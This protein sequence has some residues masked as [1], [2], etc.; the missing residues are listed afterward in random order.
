MLN[1][2]VTNVANNGREVFIWHRAGKTLSLFKDNSYFPYFYQESKTGLFKT[3]DNKKVNKIFCSRPS[4]VSKRRDENSYEADVL[5]YRRYVIDKI[6]S[7]LP[8]ELKYSFVDIEVQCPELPSILNPIYPIVCISCSN[9]YTQEIKTFSITAF[10]S[11]IPDISDEDAEKGVLSDF[12]AWIR[13]EKFD[14]LAGWNFI[15]FDY[16]YLRAR[17][18]KL[19]GKELADE[20]SPINSNRIVGK[21]DEEDPLKIP[22][23]LG[24]VDYLAWFKKIY[25]GRHS[26][27]LDYIAQEE[28]KETAY[29]KVDFNV[30]SD[31]VK[32]KN[33]NDVRRMVDIEKKLKIINYF[34]ELRRMSKSDWQDLD[35]NC[36]DTKTEILTNRGWKKYNQITLEDKVYSM[37]L[38]NQKLELKKIDNIFIYNDY[39]GKMISYEH[40][41]VNFC[42]TL[43]HRFLMH[44]YRP[45]RNIDKLEF[46]VADEITEN[47]RFFIVGTEGFEGQEFLLDNQVRLIGW[48]LSEGHFDSTCKGIHIYQNIGKKANIIRQLLKDLKLEFSEYHYPQSQVTNKVINFRILAHND[49]FY[50]DLLK[51]KKEIPNICYNLSVRQ[52]R[53]LIE[54]MMQGDGHWYTKNSGCYYSSSFALIEQ[55]QL[56]ATL[57]GY[58]VRIESDIRKRDDKIYTNYVARILKKKNVMYRNYLKNYIDYKGKIWCISTQFENF[59]IRRNNKVMISG[60]SKM[61]DMMLLTE[62]HQKGIV[63]PSKKYGV[64]TD[65]TF[66]GAYRRCDTGLYKNLWKLDL[67]SAY[68]MA[69]IN[70][71][72]DVQ[73]IKE[74]EGID[75]NGTKFYQNSSA[76]LPSLARKLIIKKDDL[77]KQLKALDPESNEAKDLQVKYDAVKGVVNSLFGVCGLKVFRLFDMRVAGA[78]TFIVRDLL[79]YI[80]AELEKRSVKIIY[81]DTDSVF[82]DSKENPKDMLNQ[83]VAQW[84]KEK[85]NKDNVGIEFDLEGKIN[86]ILIVA[87]CHYIAEVD[88][89]KG[90]KKEIKGVEVKRSDSSKYMKYFQE[91]LIDKVMNDESREAIEEFIASEKEAIKQKSLIEIGFPCKVSGKTDYK[92]LPIFMRGLT[93]TQEI[94]PSFKKVAGD[95]FYYISV[96]PFGTSVR[97]S[98]RVKRSKDNSVSTLQ[99]S[100]T[101]IDK[102]VLCFDDD[103]QVHIQNIDW[104]QVIKKS[105]DSKVDKIFEAM[106]WTIEKEIKVKKDKKIK[107][108]KIVTVEETRVSKKDV[109]TKNFTPPTEEIKCLLE[110]NVLPKVDIMKEETFNISH[111][112][113]TKA[114]ITER[115]I[116]VA[117]AFGLGIDE[118]KS[119]TLYDN[120]ELKFK[121]GDIVYITG[122][123]GSGK[124]WMLNNIFAKLDNSIAISDLKVDDNE[125]IVEGVGKDLND[126]LM[127]L[128]IAGLGDAFLYL[129]KYSQLSDGQKYRY[130]IAKFIDQD[131]DIWIL[132]EFCATLDRVTAKVVAYNLQKIARKLNKTIVVA[133]THTDLLEE[134]RPTVHIVKG[135]ESD[136]VITYYNHSNWQDKKLEF[137]QDIKVEVGTKD[138]YSALKRFHYRQAS[139]GAVKHIYKCTYKN[140]LIGVMVITYPHLAL[141]ARN[142]YTNNL[143]SKMTKENC[144]QINKNFSCIARVVLHPKWRGIGLAHYFVKEYLEKFSDTKYVETLA[145]M[146]RYSAFFAR[147]GMIQVEVDDDTLRVNLVKQLEEFGYNTSLLSSI[148][149]NEQIFNTLTSEQKDKIKEIV[150]IILTKYKGQISKLYSSEKSID[151]LVEEHLFA[152]MKELQRP[153]TLYWIWE[154]K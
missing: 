119:F 110:V 130:R 146:S 55:F 83:L 150:K 100:E 122:D 144:E 59:I 107:E 26:Y 138:D 16:Q 54:T 43:N 101:E 18:Y 128:N 115:T 25:K 35:W 111:S 133:T 86:K 56:L 1:L 23:G 136:I 34:D 126:A 63:L 78:I 104:K 42:C 152:L 45:I 103:N 131:K 58:N 11:N 19:F 95:S 22:T 125:V 118:E 85:Y 123:S 20:L 89:K 15:D 24:I 120:V 91:T 69:I 81:I 41:R 97:K 10:F 134:I 153:D 75:I 127:K 90:I 151:A 30:L 61:L 2:A 77:K 32:E 57:A 49:G 50:R 44:N 48:I 106:K 21:K 154:K 7:F 135:Y 64:E 53:L 141:K 60:N 68:P 47:G 5:Y 9:S 149:Y 116:M 13:T 108:T 70:F 96:L 129:R 33:I 52:K 39:K 66:E 147:A 117:E 148:R 145:V 92:S 102:N 88:T 132:D 28:L 137:Y 31:K 142:I 65:E 87:L 112:F 109:W 79:H 94:L 140:D 17:Y 74:N 98:S 72:L 121:S 124:S 93:Y 62:A 36:L 80:E 71:C 114:D 84:A 99:T 12:I 38:N 37:N 143:Y 29:E 73:N 3:I 139:L 4:D 82:V 67:S 6:S 113:K 8:C 40:E 27:A 76:L 14:F 51:A 105:I 46:N